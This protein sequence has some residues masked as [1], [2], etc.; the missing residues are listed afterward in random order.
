MVYVGLWNISVLEISPK[1]LLPTTYDSFE[2]FQIMMVLY[3][4]RILLVEGTLSEK[5]PLVELPEEIRVQ[6]PI[7]STAVG[8]EVDICK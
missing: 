6:H 3:Q 4:M 7:T 8:T 1:Y 5:P 2:Q